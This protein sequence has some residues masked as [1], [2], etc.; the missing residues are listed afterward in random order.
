MTFIERWTYILAVVCYAPLPSDPPPA[1]AAH[2][3]AA[4]HESAPQVRTIL[5]QP[6]PHLKS[7]RLQVEMVQVRYGPGESSRPHSHPCPVVG[8]VLEGAVR[9][10]VQ[11]HEAV[12]PETAR[13]Y[14]AG[15]SFYESPNGRHLVS[16][17]ASQFEPAV[18]LATFVC[19]HATALVVPMPNAKGI[20]Q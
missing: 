9:M 6:L 14:H 5:T 17:N 1:P 16:A 10:Q 12:E 4:M 18:F 13:I 8:Y 2:A 7:D 15:D 20:S 11:A 3:S 19:D